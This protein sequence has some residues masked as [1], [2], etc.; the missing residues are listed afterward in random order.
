MLWYASRRREGALEAFLGGQYVA[1]H[2]RWHRRRRYLKGGLLTAGLCL[3]VVAG[4]RPRVGTELQKVARQGAD[5]VLVIDTSDS[6][7]AQDVTPNRL[8]A[9]K[10]AALALV[11]RLEGDRI[12]IVVFAGSAYTY[13][14]LTIDNEAASMFVS[15]IQRGSA[16]SPGTALKAGLSK[17][18]RL[19][20]RAEHGHRAIVLFSDGEDLA[21]G[22]PGSSEPSAEGSVSPRDGIR[23]H[24]VGF[25]GTEGEPI[26]L[27]EGGDNEGMEP[28]SERGSQSPS[29]ASGPPPA[30]SRLKRDKQGEIVLT[31]INEEMLADIARAGGGVF[32]KSSPTGAN[33]DRVYQAIAGMET[34][35]VGTHEFTQYAERF[36]WPLGLAVLLL[37]LDSLISAAPR[38]RGGGR[39]EG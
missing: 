5:V 27:P 26:P 34:G 22:A 2:W 31:R 17:A 38:R 37:V 10:Q 25:G 32:V 33:I 12:G 7:L 39:G 14:P 36:Q 35:V 23:V 3:V 15:S 1:A 16:P 8:E 20:E 24:V 11:G 6:M 30:R 28:D 29:N 4:A 21:G 18:R 9:A 19:L 13:T